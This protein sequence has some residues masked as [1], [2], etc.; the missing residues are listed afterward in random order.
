MKLIEEMLEREQAP[1]ILKLNRLFSMG[2]MPSRG[3]ESYKVIHKNTN[4]ETTFLVNCMA[5]SCF[6][7][8][9]QQL[10]EFDEL[11]SKNFK[12]FYWEGEEQSE[13]YGRI[14]KFVRRTGLKVE[15]TSLSHSVGKGQWK[16]AV[17]FI[18][19]VNDER[20]K[21]DFHFILQEKDGVW[22]SKEGS[23]PYIR[24]FDIPPKHFIS[25]FGN[26]KPY[27]L[28]EYLMITNPIAQEKAENFA[29]E[30]LQKSQF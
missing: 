4:N 7:L 27:K 21:P 29:N 11:D 22:S 16:I 15:R 1:T 30:A 19:R 24:Y 10:A 12:Q 2:Y 17:Y 6:N 25:E 9:N 28:H 3:D 20:K 8:T 18:D 13:I 5:H 26:H 23:F 14:L